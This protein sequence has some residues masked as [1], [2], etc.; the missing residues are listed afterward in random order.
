[1]TNLY[2]KK[3]ICCPSYPVGAYGINRLNDYIEALHEGFVDSGLYDECSKEAKKIVLWCTGSSGAICAA[4]FIAKLPIVNVAIHHIKK[5]GENSHASRIPV[6]YS[7]KD[8]NIVIDDFIASGKT[9]KR[10]E[11]AVR[12]NLR[13]KQSIVR[14]NE[15]KKEGF[16][17]L[18]IASGVH[19]ELLPMF[20]NI[21]TSYAS[22]RV[23]E[24]VNLIEL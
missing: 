8:F 5:S 22:D 1:M 2:L 23:R 20:K 6:S 14:A 4:L 17:L 10:I 7:K 13:N 24:H 12:L 19:F 3:E 21:I 11:S 16:D 18:L 15:F 9:I